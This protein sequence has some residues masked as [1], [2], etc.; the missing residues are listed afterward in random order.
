MLGTDGL[1]PL[2]GVSFDK[3]TEGLLLQLVGDARLD[4]KVRLG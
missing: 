3:A 2:A 4:V 1:Q